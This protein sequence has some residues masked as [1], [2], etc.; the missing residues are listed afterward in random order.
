MKVYDLRTEYRKNPIGLATQLPGFSWKMESEK[1]NTVQK[2]YAISVMKEEGTVVWDSGVVESEDS[3]LVPYGGKPLDPE[4]VY[5]CL[6]YT[7]PSP[8]D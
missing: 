8:R 5:R 2:S 6:L 7:S 4:T 3:V 1:Q